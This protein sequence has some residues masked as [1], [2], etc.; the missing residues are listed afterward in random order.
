MNVA[1]IRYANPHR[2]GSF[3]SFDCVAVCSTDALNSLE[4]PYCHALF[5]FVCDSVASPPCP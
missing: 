3:V 1:D 4:E 5:A 2:D